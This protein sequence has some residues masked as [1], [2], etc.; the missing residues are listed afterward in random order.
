[1]MRDKFEVYVSFCCGGLWLPGYGHDDIVGVVDPDDYPNAAAQQPSIYSVGPDS[2]IGQKDA[3][4]VAD[5]FRESECPACGTRQSLLEE[6][7][8]F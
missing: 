2:T 6:V 8:G 1:M 5:A 4:K 7:T 3:S